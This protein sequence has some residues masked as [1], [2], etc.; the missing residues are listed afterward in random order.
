MVDHIIEDAQKTCGIENLQIYNVRIRR[1]LTPK[2][3]LLK[4]LRPIDV[5]CAHG[6]TVAPEDKHAL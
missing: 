1:K 4:N 5:R 3:E 6:R 2:P